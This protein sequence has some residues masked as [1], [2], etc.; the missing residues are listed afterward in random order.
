MLL[1]RDGQAQGVTL[2]DGTEVRSKLVLSNASPQITFLELIPQVQGARGWWGLGVAASPRPHCPLTA[3][4]CTGISHP[5]SSCRRILSI[6]SGRL[7]HAPQSP[8]SMVG[9]VRATSTAVPAG[10]TL[11]PGSAKGCTLLPRLPLS[12]RPVA[13][14]RLPSFLAAPNA[15]DGRPLPHHQCSIHL[16]CEGTHLL[17]Q[18]FTEATQGHPSSR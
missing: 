10:G 9:T 13:V 17:H 6:G 14:D 2:Q 16:N 5:R 8:R 15:R 3:S 12:P 4:L 11:A 1:G 18:A 7:T